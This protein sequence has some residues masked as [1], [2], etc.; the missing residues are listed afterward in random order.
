MMRGGAFK[1]QRLQG[2]A[3]GVLRSGHGQGMKDASVKDAS[4]KADVVRYSILYT[5][6]A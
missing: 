3:Y 2:M 1:Q 5:Q 6:C 4:M